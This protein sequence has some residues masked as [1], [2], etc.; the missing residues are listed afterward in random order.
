MKL[1]YEKYKHYK[2]FFRETCLKGASQQLSTSSPDLTSF[3]DPLGNLKVA[4]KDQRNDKLPHPNAS[5]SMM[6]LRKNKLRE[7]CCSSASSSDAPPKQLPTVNRVRTNAESRHKF[8]SEATSPVEA[9]QIKEEWH[10]YLIIIAVRF[11]LITSSFM[12]MLLLIVSIWAMVV[13]F[14]G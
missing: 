6:V 14:F 9:G 11:A 4:S 13:E 1:V 12:F 3:D 5:K 10:L 2:I 8:L 7:L